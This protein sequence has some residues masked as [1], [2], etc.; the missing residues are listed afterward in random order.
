MEW[1]CLSC[2]N[3]RIT[4]HEYQCFHCGSTDLVNEDDK[5]YQEE[6]EPAP[7]DGKGALFP[8]PKRLI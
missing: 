1:L 3:R 8:S 4:G 2:G 5:D 6:N 7:T